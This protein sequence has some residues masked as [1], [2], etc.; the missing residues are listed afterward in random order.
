[1][2]TE[3]C[4]NLI[5]AIRKAQGRHSASEGGVPLTAAK[6]SLKSWSITGHLRH[7]NVPTAWKASRLHVQLEVG[8]LIPAL[9]L[10]P[11][12]F[13]MDIDV[14]LV[15][16]QTW[17]LTLPG[18]TSTKLR[19]R[20]PCHLT[21]PNTY[22]QLVVWVAQAVAHWLGLKVNEVKSHLANLRQQINPVTTRGRRGN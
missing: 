15:S 5:L 22:F 10:P 8:R 18:N 11:L 21:R 14:R 6:G 12:P 13:K 2:V 16:G 9:L 17:P 7:P 1:M 19:Y 3:N 20:H 4:D